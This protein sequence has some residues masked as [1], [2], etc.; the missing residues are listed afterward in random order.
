M[1]VFASP[2]VGGS[3]ELCSEVRWPG[4][5]AGATYSTDRQNGN[6]DSELSLNTYRSVTRILK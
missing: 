2:T 1:F 3:F 5:A 4:V 6:K